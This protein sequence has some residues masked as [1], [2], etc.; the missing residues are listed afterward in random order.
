MKNAEKRAGFLEEEVIRLKAELARLKSHTEKDELIR[1]LNETNAMI[2]LGSWGLNLKT[3]VLTLSDAYRHIYNLKPGQTLTVE[4]ALQFYTPESQSLLKPAVDELISNG[5][6]FDLELEIIDNNGSR[7]WVR[8][9]GKRK[10]DK[11]APAMVYGI[12]QDISEQKEL[13][14]KITQSEMLYHDLFETNQALKLIIDP[15]SGKI[16]DANKA[17][18][19]FYGYGKSQLTKMTIFDINAQSRDKVEKE[20][21]NAK[22]GGKRYFNFKHKLASGAIRNVEV[23]SGPIEVGGKHLLYSIVHDITE[24]HRGELMRDALLNISKTIVG[25]KSVGE[26]LAA[27]QKQI[28]VFI[29]SDNFFVALYD[30]QNQNYS[31]P[32]YSDKYSPIADFSADEMKNS[33]TDYVRRSGK[34]LLL[35]RNK[36]RKMQNSGDVHLVG[37]ESMIWMGIP[38]TTAS[39]VQGVVVIQNYESQTAYNNQDLQV[40]EFVAEHIAHAIELKRNELQLMESEQRYRML[41]NRSPLCI[42]VH[43][44]GKIVFANPM[45]IKMLGAKNEQDLLGKEILGFVHP[46]SIEKVTARLKILDSGQDVSSLDEKFL[47]IDGNELDVSV[48]GGPVLYNNKPAV[49][50]VFTVIT[51][52]KKIQRALVESEKSYRALF[53]N[54]MDAIYIQDKNGAFLDVNKSVNKLYSGYSHDFFIGKTPMDVALPGANDMDEVRTKFE[55]AYNGKP[56]SFDF[57]AVKKDGMPFLKEVHVAASNYFGQKVVIAYARDITEERHREQVLRQS[58][59]R[60]RTLVENAPIGIGVSRDN[61]IL[62]A[63]ET[64]SELFG[65]NKNEFTG[66]DEKKLISDSDARKHHLLSIGRQQGKEVE[67][68]Y[69]IIAR[70]KDGLEFPLRVRAGNILLE[71]GPAILVFL[72]DLTAIRKAEEEQKTMEKQVLQTQKLESLGVLAGGI[73]HDFNNMLTGILGNTTLAMMEIPD[74]C[75]ARDNLQKVEQISSHAAELCVQMLSYSGKGSV[76]VVPMDLNILIKEMVRLLNVSIPGKVHFI[77]NFDSK[78]PPVNADATNIRQIVMN[79]ITNAAEAIG[80]R[81]GVINLST[82][83][84]YFSAAELQ[85]AY[86]DRIPDEKEYVFLEVTDNGCGM[87]EETLMRLFDPFFTTKFTGRGLGMAAVLGIVR[88]HQGS[89]KIDSTPGIGTTIRIYFPASEKKDVT[90]RMDQIPLD[91]KQGKGT[92]LVVDDDKSI[93]DIVSASLKTFGYTV[94]TANDGSEGIEVFKDNQEKI[95]MVILDMIMPKLTGMEVYHEIK[96][97]N[98]DIKA[99][100]SSGYTVEDIPASIDKDLNINYLQKPFSISELINSITNIMGNNTPETGRN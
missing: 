21:L 34:A 56:Q 14:E 73:A 71:D 97:L 53:D 52:Q 33:L 15:N 82:G 70:K 43:Q 42:V 20:I 84:G 32:F 58:E 72:S 94:L 40:M 77:Q 50:V 100:L 27:I 86:L 60:F 61:K 16:V 24:R 78:I 3:N 37:R 2:K 29:D 68:T 88:S 36:D 5:T 17:A 38:F 63:N 28:S 11:D 59:A 49:Q 35:D 26:L 23:Y 67:N 22:A 18:M 91:P 79:L 87:N 10:L 7:K 13:E 4:Q 85:S 55:A 90:A 41:V 92:I 65:Y 19:K 89:L 98:P 74:D 45:A 81:E 46:K 31:F 95:Q 1:L 51:E 76:K 8:C 66:M 30:N 99:L 47:Q 69:E 62:F 12:M 9:S 57:W 93:R 44:Q 96:E 39:G 54:A 25:F 6:K 83:F 80:E 75:R 64:M 48:Q